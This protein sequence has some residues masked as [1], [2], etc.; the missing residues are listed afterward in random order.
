[1]PDPE[2]ITVHLMKGEG[3][4]KTIHR[5]ISVEDLIRDH[6]GS[7]GFMVRKGL[8][9][10]VCG[11]PAWG[12]FEEVA[13]RSGKPDSEVNA[14]IEE[15]QAYTSNPYIMTAYG[16]FVGALVSAGSPG[17]KEKNSAGTSPTEAS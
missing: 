5:L 12:T 6:P 8:P 2:T 13:R 15:L 7:V 9:C 3:C 4:M 1:M 17:K 14:L 10:F 11:E 16:A